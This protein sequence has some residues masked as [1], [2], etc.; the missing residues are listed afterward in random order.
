[1][2]KGK[3]HQAGGFGSKSQRTAFAQ[4]VQEQALQLKL[5]RP[6]N[7]PQ[8]QQSKRSSAERPRFTRLT[9]LKGMLRERQSQEAYGLMERRR[10]AGFLPRRDENPAPRAE[11][12]ASHPP[13]WIIYYGIEK[14]EQTEE[15]VESL[16]S[17]CVDVMSQY[18]LEYLE[19]LGRDELH[20][21]LSL[22]PSETLATLSVVISKQFGI[23]NDLAIV[24]GK[25]AHVEALCFRAAQNDETLNDEAIMELVPHLP[26]QGV[27]DSW[28]DLQ[29]RDD[30]LVDVM[31]LEGCNIRL[32]R[33]E[34]L[35]CRSI[36]ADAL[37]ALLEKCSCITH[38]SLAGSLNGVEDGVRVLRA[39]PDLLPALQV[40]DVTNCAWMT[41]SLLDCFV[42]CY[43]NQKPPVVHH[44]GCYTGPY[45]GSGHDW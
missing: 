17:K 7:R 18:I 25:H 9:Q 19:A 10:R 43:Q 23:D 13:G 15:S 14:K 4:E 40:L 6:S 16:Q 28:E 39:I 42:Q 32:R 33:L 26:T 22:V 20:A 21:A 36:S 44:Q 35:D 34:L 30:A 2:G 37:I 38:L 41:T 1:M 3:G 5:S 27:Q 45:Q 29:D 8:Q 31:Q 11:Q 24:L 12:I